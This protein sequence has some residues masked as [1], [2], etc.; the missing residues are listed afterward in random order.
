MGTVMQ[1]HTHKTL[2]APRFFVSTRGVL[3]ERRANRPS[4]NAGY[5][6]E[7]NRATR[8]EMQLLAD[9]L[10]EPE[11]MRQFDN[12]WSP[13]QA[14]SEKI[15]QLARQYRTF[16]PALIFPERCRLAA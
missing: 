1:R 8:S 5:S 16:L 13:D 10:N 15:D 12:G 11:T 2:A 6:I 9:M 7:A 3:M 4:R 14:W